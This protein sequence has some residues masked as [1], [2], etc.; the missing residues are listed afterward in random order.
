[1]PLRA[2][3]DTTPHAQGFPVHTGRVHPDRFVVPKPRGCD[4]L[5]RP[6]RFACV[7]KRDNRTPYAFGPQGRPA[8]PERSRIARAP[9]CVDLSE[10]AKLLPKLGDIPPLAPKPHEAVRV[11]T[12]HQQTNPATGRLLDQYA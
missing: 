3:Q 10:H 2:I 6:Q 9:D 11:I 1:M 8:Q 4:S 7:L 5:S 12:T